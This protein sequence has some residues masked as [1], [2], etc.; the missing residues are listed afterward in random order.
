MASGNGRRLMIRNG[1]LID[2]SGAPPTANDAI[3]IEDGVIASVGALPEGIAK[4]NDPPEVID[5]TGRFIMPG[6]IDGHC[7]LS[8]H[9]GA[10]QGI[11]YPASAEFSTIWAM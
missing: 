7:H 3:L 6:M 9:Q 2:G 4:R 8:L 11:R 10:P 5:A 1:T